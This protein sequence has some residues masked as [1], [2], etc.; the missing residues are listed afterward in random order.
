MVG[1]PEWLTTNRFPS[2]LKTQPDRPAT[3]GGPVSESWRP[4]SAS[5]MRRNSPAAATTRLPSGRKASTPVELP[6]AATPRRAGR[7]AGRSLRPRGE[8]CTSPPRSMPHSR[9][10]A[11]RRGCRAGAE[12]LP[13]P[14]QD[15]LLPAGRRIP[16]RGSC[17]RAAPLASCR[18]SGLYSSD[19]T[20][21]ACPRRTGPGRPVAASKRWTSPRSFP[22]AIC[23]ASGLSRTVK[24]VDLGHG[25]DEAR[26]IE[27][28]VKVAP[29]PVAVFLGCGLAGAA[30]PCCCSATAGR[31]RPRRCSSGSAPSARPARARRPRFAARSA[32]SRNDRSSRAAR[33]RSAVRPAASRPWRAPARP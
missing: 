31:R 11:G 23:R 29:L 15:E 26:A 9:R 18:P 10:S 32:S 19:S 21:P 3:P 4:V 30:P 14:A 33:W 17:R 22:T 27:L 16:D 12:S 2:G 8:T 20:A 13:F 28:A 1:P 24:I 7:A 6:V 25:E 5:Y